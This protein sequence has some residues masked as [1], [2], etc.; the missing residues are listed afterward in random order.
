MASDNFTTI[1][2]LLIG[3]ALLYLFKK[4]REGVARLSSSQLPELSEDD[5]NT[6]KVL[7]K[8]AYERMLYLAVLFFPLAFFNGR[9]DD[10][11]GVIFFLLLIALLFLSNIP[12]RHK[13][14]G[15]LTRNGLSVR[16]LEQRGIK[17]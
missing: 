8:T 5:F 3:V 15:L 9:G 7:L 6:L 12:P 4:R 11:I 10:R 16:I 2:Y 13:I 1:L 14:I 17:L